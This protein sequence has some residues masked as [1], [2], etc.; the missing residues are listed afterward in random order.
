MWRRHLVA[1]KPFAHALA[2]LLEQQYPDDVVADMKKQIRT[3]K[4]LV[5][6]SQNDEHKTTVA[7]MGLFL[8]AQE[9]AAVQY[10]ARCVLDVP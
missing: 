8:A 10:F 2:R 3:G 4:V 7:V 1:G 5:D 9:A 6:W